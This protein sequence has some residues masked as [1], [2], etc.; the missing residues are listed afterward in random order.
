MIIGQSINPNWKEARRGRLTASDFGKI[1]RRKSETLPDNLLKYILGYC[2]TFTNTAVEW[3]REHEKVAVD[4]YT[5]P[6]EGEGV[7]RLD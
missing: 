7:R 6:T 2:P 4:S 5:V 3:G 1:V